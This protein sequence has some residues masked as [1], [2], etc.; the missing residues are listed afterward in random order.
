LLREREQ[1]FWADW[2]EKDLKLIEGE[3]FY[4]IEDLLK[5]FHGGIAGLSDVILHPPSKNAE[6]QW[7]SKR[8]YEIAH[9]LQRERHRREA[10]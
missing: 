7:L 3:D 6:W 10:I 1:G 5:A 8:I 2:L 9:G 4:G